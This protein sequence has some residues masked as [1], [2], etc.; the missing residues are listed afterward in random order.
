MD[1]SVQ[2]CR[3]EQIL[4]NSVSGDFLLIKRLKTSLVFQ[5][6]GRSTKEPSI[7]SMHIAPGAFVHLLIP[8]AFQSV[9]LQAPFAQGEMQ[10]ISEDECLP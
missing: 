5:E 8:S 6:F 4:K 10:N 7:R 9:A 3:S 2:R 1:L